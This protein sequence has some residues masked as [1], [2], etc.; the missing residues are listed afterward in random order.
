MKVDAAGNVYLAGNL[1]APDSDANPFVSSNV[2]YDTEQAFLIKFSPATNKILYV[3]HIGGGPID[4][5]NV[6][7][8]DAAGNAYLCGITSSATFP[9]VNAFQRQ[10]K[11]P[12]PLFTGFVTKVSADGRSLL[13]RGP[14]SR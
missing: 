1:Y 2:A 5:A 10:I 6:V 9:L 8:L 12:P 3:V 7:A 14:A 13:P 4:T 11:V